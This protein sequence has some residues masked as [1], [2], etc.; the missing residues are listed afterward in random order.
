LWAV[1]WWWILSH[2]HSSLLLVS[3][4]GVEFPPQGT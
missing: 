4:L 3:L 1:V 2:D